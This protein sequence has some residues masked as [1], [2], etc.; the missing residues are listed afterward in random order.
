MSGR[1]VGL[2]LIE[3]LVAVVIVGI[4][5]AAGIVSLASTQSTRLEAEARTIVADLAWARHRAVSTHEDSIVVFDP[6]LDE[7]VIEGVTTNRELCAAILEAPDFRRGT[8]TTA[9]ME[10]NGEELLR[11][12][13]GSAGA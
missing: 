5:G 12:V 4:L 3:L 6:A 10:E 7:Y 2:T 1:R 9:F 8:Y 13:A 11:Q